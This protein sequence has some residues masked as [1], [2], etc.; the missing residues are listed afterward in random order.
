MLDNASNNDTLVEGITNRAKQRGVIMNA[1]WIRLRCMPH[2][3]HLAALKVWPF[4]FSTRTY[5][6]IVIQLLE[7]IGAISATECKKAMSRRG[8]Y[9]DSIAAPIDRGSD[10]DAVARDGEDE[11]DNPSLEVDPTSSMLSA[12]EKVL[13]LIALLLN[14]NIIT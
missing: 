13:T 4:N 7:G 5:F 12:V 1:N 11:Q 14:I 3:V 6:L 10:D 2:T 8:N 9:Q